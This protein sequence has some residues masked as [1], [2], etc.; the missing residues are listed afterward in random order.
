MYVSSVILPSQLLK[1]QV[2]ILVKNKANK[3][4]ET[5]LY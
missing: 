4:K 2:K 3:E 5:S 1:K